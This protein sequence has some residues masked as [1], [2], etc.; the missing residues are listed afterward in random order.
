MTALLTDPCSATL[1]LVSFCLC[2]NFNNAC[3]SEFTAL[4]SE[5]PELALSSRVRDCAILSYPNSSSQK[6]INYKTRCCLLNKHLHYTPVRSPVPFQQPRLVRSVPH[7][8]HRMMR[9]RF[10]ISLLVHGNCSAHATCSRFSES[11]LFSSFPFSPPMF[12][13][14]IEQK[15]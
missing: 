2:F 10:P 7:G 1:C 3:I 9:S 12:V 13:L 4:P 6:W 14:R 5:L 15:T 8:Q 11:S